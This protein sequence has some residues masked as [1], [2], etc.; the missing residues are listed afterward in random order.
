L[1]ESEA[2]EWKV[3][4]DELVAAGRATRCGVREL[5][6]ALGWEGG[7][8]NSTI[9]PTPPSPPQSGSKLPHSKFVAAERIAL[10]RLAFPDAVSDPPL[11]E[12]PRSSRDLAVDDAHAARRE[13]V[14]GWMDSIGPTTAAALA[15][16]LGMAEPAVDG[17][18]A[19]LEADGCILRGTFT[20]AAA[21]AVEWC[22]RGLLSRIH[23]LTLGRLRREI[24]AVSPADFFRF[25]LTWQHVQPGTQLHGRD[26]VRHIIAQLQGL[27]LPGPA[28]ERDVLA[29]RIAE[30]DPRDL[31]QLCLAGEVAWGR[32][33][34]AAASEGEEVVHAP[35]RRRAMP[36]RAAPLAFV[37][38]ADLAD[39]LV[40]APDMTQVLAERSPAA[41][42]VLEYLEQRGAS[43]LADIAR[44]LGRLPTEVEDALWELVASGLVTGD[45]IAGLR[46]LLL[47]ERER[48]PR[49][50]HLRALPGGATRR[51]MPVGRWALLRDREEAAPHGEVVAERAARRLLLRWGVVFREL[52]ARE[53]GLPS[54]RAVLFALRRLEARGEVRG[55]RFVDGFVGEQFA[56]PEAVDTMRSVRR[57]GATGEPVL[58]AAADPLN[59]VGILTQ[60]ARVSP[61][62]GLVIAYRDGVPIEIG[63]LG[64]VRSRLQRAS[65]QE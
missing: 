64:A 6:P 22:E 7:G 56:L 53:R 49:R 42:A 29:A 4:L 57:R 37:L 21:G 12:P 1:P 15:E 44:G 27:E 39:L 61:F 11:V 31:E 63:E 14:R 2:G 58:V 50:S 33:A 10:V 65:S 8:G 13:I 5:A 51:L 38:R 35:A 45:G 52:C 19:Q 26:G 3:W 34:V 47:P 23:R 59:L 43:F 24:E 17:A 54:W 41:R 9:S 32:L 18:L 48:R 30:Y 40:A 16:R 28:W 62:S 46:T 20:S 60:G 25:L 55:G 36:T